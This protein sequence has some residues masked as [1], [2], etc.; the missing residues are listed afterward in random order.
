MSFVVAEEKNN[1][2]LNGLWRTEVIVSCD[3][4]ENYKCSA[5]VYIGCTQRKFKKVV[6]S[7]LL[8]SNTRTQLRYKA[9]KLLLEFSRKKNEETQAINVNSNACELCQ[10]FDI[11]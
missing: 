8:I 9:R 10:K 5:K 1:C 4:V 7:Y 11:T 2:S 6:Y 3:D